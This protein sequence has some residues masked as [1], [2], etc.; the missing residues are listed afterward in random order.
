MAD[1]REPRPEDRTVVGHL[2]AA[3]ARIDLL[4]Y[5]CEGGM[6]LEVLHTCWPSIESVLG[7]GRQ[8]KKP[9]TVTKCY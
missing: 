4:S 3:H 6:H 5:T 7:P 1:G 2:P 8:G 9:Y